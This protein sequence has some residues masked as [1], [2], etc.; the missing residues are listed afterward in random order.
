MMPAESSS[1][2]EPNQREQFAEN[3]FLMVPRLSS[4][5]QCEMISNELTEQL[6]Q[7]QGV[8]PRMRGGSRNVLRS[9]P[10]ARQFAYSSPVISL[11]SDLLGA[12]A[13][14]VRG[15]FFDKN[16]S[17]N[18]S[19]PWHQDLAIAVGARKETPGFGP[20]SVKGGIVHVQP[21]EHVL[22]GM[23]TVRLHLDDCAADNGAL[24]VIPGSHCHGELSTDEITAWAG[25]PQLVVCEVPQGGAL[26]MRPLLLHSSSRVKEPSHRRVLHIEYA[27]KDLPDGLEWFERS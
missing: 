26:V 12:P 11:V 18:W 21:P 6:D 24:R 27:S 15:M 22:A 13:F 7:E 10:L 25:R 20:W 1:V 5:A 2:M 16:A 19:V 14:P 17:A 23:T 3:G 8:L 4:V 9:R